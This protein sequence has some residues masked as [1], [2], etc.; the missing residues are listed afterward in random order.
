MTT[1]DSGPARCPTWTLQCRIAQTTNLNFSG[2]AFVLT[3]FSGSESLERVGSGSIDYLSVRPW[4]IPAPA[5]SI[6]LNG[7]AQDTLSIDETQNPDPD[8]YVITN[9]GIS[10][11]GAS[12]NVSFAGI[13]KLEVWGGKHGASF[14]VNSTSGNFR[15]D[16]DVIHGIPEAFDRLTR[17][18]ASRRDAGRRVVLVKYLGLS[19]TKATVARLAKEIGVW[20]VDP[21]ATG[22]FSNL[23]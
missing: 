10:R 14:D 22:N 4:L 23:S 17:D 19:E 3:L 6:S 7:T 13:G 15:Q 5:D 8:T 21:K 18:I 16:G 11:D 9:T 1:L 20:R 2:N 12:L